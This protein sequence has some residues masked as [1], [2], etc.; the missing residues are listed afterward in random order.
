MLALTV[1]Y[2][3]LK[4]N[5]LIGPIAGLSDTY[6]Y[7]A[8]ALGIAMSVFLSR[9]FAK[10]NEELEVQL[11]QVRDLSER[12]MVHERQA[13]E[14][15]IERRLLEADNS[16]KTEEL[17]EARKL[18]LSMLPQEIPSLS[19]LDI[20]VYMRTASE[21][22]GDY[23]D[24]LLD[25][26]DTLTVAV[27]DATGHGMKA[28]TLV[29]VIKGLVHQLRSGELPRVFETI[30]GVIRSMNLGNL[31]MSLTLLRIRQTIPA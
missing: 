25:Q 18:Q 26:D 3:V 2:E 7:G 16:R 6:I 14:A 10:T 27:G 12:T 20:A 17:E 5:N 30:S 24:F 4:G 23:Y 21:V 28:G 11:E 19:E 9:R 22:G 15:E 13:R 29:A 8:L 1:L 31:Y